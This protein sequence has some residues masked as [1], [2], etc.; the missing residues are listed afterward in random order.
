MEPSHRDILQAYPGL[1]SWLHGALAQR[2]FAGL[3]KPLVV[4]TWPPS[5]R[6]IS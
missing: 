3:S 1:W 4:A 5:Y 2:Y 6:D